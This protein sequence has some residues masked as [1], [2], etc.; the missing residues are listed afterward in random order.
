MVTVKNTFTDTTKDLY[1]AILE[2]L[3]GTMAEVQ[4]RYF[5]TGDDLLYA[6]LDRLNSGKVALLV[7][8]F[9][10]AADTVDRSVVNYP[11]IIGSA[12]LLI[13]IGGVFLDNAV[14]EGRYVLY[15]LTDAAVGGLLPGDISLPPVAAGEQ[16]NIFKF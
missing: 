15:N 3:G 13:S 11:G 12:N 1:L 14:I 5:S 4:N 10:A 8:S 6:I 2:A 9:R 7:D 16:V